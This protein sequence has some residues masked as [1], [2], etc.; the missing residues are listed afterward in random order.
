MQAFIGPDV[1]LGKDVKV[2]PFAHIDGHTTIGD[3]SEIF[4]HACLGGPPQDLSYKGSPTMLVIGEKAVI[5]EG[6]S[7]HRASE[8]EDRVT[9]VGARLYLMGNA[10]I[11]HD[12]RIGDDVIITHGSALGGHCHIGDRAIIGGNSSIHQHCRIGTMVMIGGGTLAIQDVPPYCLAQGNPARLFGLNEVGLDRR[13]FPSATISA[14]RKVYRLL[15]R[16]DRT[17]KDAVAA[18]RGEWGNVPEV[19]GL[20]AFLDGSKRG[21]ARHG[22]GE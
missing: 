6:A 10:H 7:I 19:A 2:H 3:H 20:L 11:G 12:C 18:A 21:I 22:R 8:K 14:L 13:G 5:R 1:K 17:R 15:F 16:S 4:P 9:V